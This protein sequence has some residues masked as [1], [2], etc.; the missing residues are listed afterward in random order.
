[1]CRHPGW[2]ADPENTEVNMERKQITGCVLVSLFAALIAAG[3]FVR[4]PFV[5]VPVTL[6]TLFALMAA[7]CLPVHLAV[8]SVAAYLVLG[9]AGLPIFTSGGGFAALLGPTGGYLIGMIPAV[10][11]GGVM[12]RAFAARPKLAAVLG[13]IAADAL[14]YLIGIPWLAVSMDISITAALVSGLVPFI[15]GDALKI[16]VAASVSPLIRPR[17][18][19][20]L[21]RE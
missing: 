19:E 20:M 13:S 5:P 18:L 14:I 6:Q 2:H 7:L 4:I 9:A 16:A 3:A 10:I 21:E 12:A 17:V 15:P 8:M 1:M 11:A